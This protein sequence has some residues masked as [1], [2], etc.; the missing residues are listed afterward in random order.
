MII[1][2]LVFSIPIFLGFL[3]PTSGTASDFHLWEECIEN[4]NNCRSN[5]T[6]VSPG[7]PPANCGNRASCND[8]CVSLPFNANNISTISMVFHD[9]LGYWV[10]NDIVGAGT[11]YGVGNV[12]GPTKDYPP[13]RPSSG[14]SN[15][16]ELERQLGP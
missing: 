15:I 5:Y 10:R 12:G 8:V 3:I 6:K 14:V 7:R 11:W 9:T 13:W 4:Q 1:K 2:L 16:Y